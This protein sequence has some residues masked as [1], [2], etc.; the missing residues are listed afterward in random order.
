M[1]TDRLLGLLL[2]A[3]GLV[4]FAMQRLAQADASIAASFAS[5]RLVA[6]FTA[7]VVCVI[8]ALLFFAGLLPRGPNHL[9]GVP[10]FGRAAEVQSP[11]RP[12]LR[13]AFLVLP[14]IVVLALLVDQFGPWRAVDPGA[15]VA[16][17]NEP[18]AEPKGQDVAGVPPDLATP[19]APPSSPPVA[20]PPA[21]TPP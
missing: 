17:P 9:S 13:H 6:L 10:L 4:C 15:E 14:A 2:L 8:G 21:Q 7:G 1:N 18:K 3:I 16:V 19:P 11:G 5:V 20:T 12:R